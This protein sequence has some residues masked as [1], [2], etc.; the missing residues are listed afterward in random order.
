MSFC[1]ILKTTLSGRNCFRTKVQRVPSP[2]LPSQTVVDRDSYP[3][4]HSAG[5]QPFKH[6]DKTPWKGLVLP[7]RPIT[8]S[9]A[10][11]STASRQRRWQQRGH[12]QLGQLGAVGPHSPLPILLFI[13]RA[14]KDLAHGTFCLCR[15]QARFLL[16]WELQQAKVK[17]VRT[18]VKARLEFHSD[19]LRK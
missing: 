8:Y 13:L 11:P 14:L 9:L 7:P 18:R 2:V 10:S 19:H 1:F 12:R 17:G 3:G 16:S 4:L 5:H 15:L 6:F